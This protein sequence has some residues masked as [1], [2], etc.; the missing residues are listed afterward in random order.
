MYMAL[1][2]VN[3]NS[4][5]VNRDRLWSDDSVFGTGSGKASFRSSGDLDNSGLYKKTVEPLYSPQ[6]NVDDWAIRSGQVTMSSNEL[7]GYT[8]DRGDVPCRRTI[9][10][11]Y[12][13]AAPKNKREVKTVYEEFFMAADETR[14]SRLVEVLIGNGNGTDTDQVTDKAALEMKNR[15]AV[16]RS[17]LS[18]ANTWNEF[19]ELLEEEAK[20]QAEGT[21]FWLAGYQKKMDVLEKEFLNK[22]YFVAG[23]Q[24]KDFFELYKLAETLEAK[25]KGSQEKIAKNQ[26]YYVHHEWFLV[27]YKGFSFNALTALLNNTPDTMKDCKNDKVSASNAWNGKDKKFKITVGYYEHQELIG[28]VGILGNKHD[29]A[30]TVSSRFAM[31]LDYMPETEEGVVKHKAGAYLGYSQGWKTDQ[32]MYRAQGGEKRL[33]LGQQILTGDILVYRNNRLL[34]QGVE[35]T[36]S[37]T[38]IEF[39]QPLLKDEEISY[40]VRRKEDLPNTVTDDHRVV[41]SGT[42]TYDTGNGTVLSLHGDAVVQSTKDEIKKKNADNTRQ[43]VVKRHGNSFSV[44]RQYLDSSHADEHIGMIRTESDITTLSMLDASE[45]AIVKEA[46]LILQKNSDPMPEATVTAKGQHQFKHGTVSESVSW[47][48]REKSLSGSGA[49]MIDSLTAYSYWDVPFADP[50]MTVT[51]SDGGMMITYNKEFASMAQVSRNISGDASNWKKKKLVFQVKGD[52]NPQTIEIRW[53][54]SANTYAFIRKEITGSDWQT[55][56]IDPEQEG[57][58]VGLGK[59]DLGAITYLSL[60]AVGQGTHTAHSVTFS[61]VSLA[62]LSDTVRPL[63]TTDVMLQYDANSAVDTK[64]IYL[65]DKHFSEKTQVDALKDRADKLIEQYMS[66]VLKNIDPQ[67]AAG[68]ISDIKVNLL[69][70]LFGGQNFNMYDMA[71]YILDRITT[72]DAGF[73]APMAEIVSGLLGIEKGTEAYTM[74]FTYAEL[75][76]L[77]NEEQ[78]TAFINTIIP[79]I[80]ACIENAATSTDFIITPAQDGGVSIFAPEDIKNAVQF[81]YRLNTF[82]ADKPETRNYT[83]TLNPAKGEDVREN[84][85]GAGVGGHVEKLDGMREKDSAAANLYWNPTEYSSLSITDATSQSYAMTDTKDKHIVNDL[86]ANGSID[87]AK[88]FGTT[89]SWV[90]RV[91]MMYRKR[92]VLVQGSEPGDEAVNS[93]ETYSMN[94][95]S[96]HV[97]VMGET[98]LGEDRSMKWYLKDSR[99]NRDIDLKRAELLRNEVLHGAILPAEISLTPEC[100]KYTGFLVREGVLVKNDLGLYVLPEG[101]TDA[102]INEVLNSEPFKA[103]PKEIR[104]IIGRAQL[105][106]ERMRLGKPVEYTGLSDT[107]RNALDRSLDLQLSED[108]AYNVL[109]DFNIRGNYDEVL[110]ATPYKNTRNHFDGKLSNGTNLLAW[111]NTIDQNIVQSE[112][113]Q[114]TFGMNN[115]LGFFQG[116][117]KQDSNR[118]LI[119]LKYGSSSTVQSENSEDSIR[120]VFTTVPGSQIFTHDFAKT[121]FKDPFVSSSETLGITFSPLT[122]ASFSVDRTVAWSGGTQVDTPSAHYTDAVKIKS[123]KDI[124]VFPLDQSTSSQN[125]GMNYA[126]GMSKHSYW[127]KPGANADTYENNATIG[128]GYHDADPNAFLK[129]VQTS[130]TYAV[131]SDANMHR[132]DSGNSVDI[133]AEIKGPTFDFFKNRGFESSS[134]KINYLYRDTLGMEKSY[135][136]LSGRWDLKNAEGNSLYLEGNWFSQDGTYNASISIGF[137]YKF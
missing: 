30:D 98:T 83:V 54:T 53:G 40:S 12:S 77:P 128:L 80:R 29:T 23:I 92:D 36:V 58:Y 66:S 7:F 72:A 97:G 113:S 31:N 56:E 37:G 32:S 112:V 18:K 22:H 65:A 75:E 126:V 101:K 93:T 19:L 76:E 26:Y 17:L 85:W 38:G 35:Y 57:I 1:G 42:Y 104:D 123:I 73:R 96:D 82:D 110:G 51:S 24:L 100:K 61:N 50:Q 33:S 121:S 43:Y 27:L 109:Y 86:S 81:R 6:M 2:G 9:E 25:K 116:P 95:A 63:Y 11:D 68:I 44:T 91:D 15:R 122:W 3:P 14:H 4:G 49:V 28:S 119:E 34:K 41:G 59:G 48:K 87:L 39:A 89:G 130:Y 111:S 74:L 124:N 134:V 88:L 103:L 70:K 99:T 133:S 20:T 62:G 71:A 60:G 84:V 135:H 94:I 16:I 67:I 21:N 45:K 115:V 137:N 107:D 125:V 118:N 129:G 78:R 127:N 69:D 13:G 52:G 10:L 120:N 79:C 47:R 5:S 131:L 102:D 106:R 105:R 55:I 136:G 117:D 46:F 132:V 108:H 64:K 114:N 8:S 90:P